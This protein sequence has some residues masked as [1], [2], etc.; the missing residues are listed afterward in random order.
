MSARAFSYSFFS[1]RK[2][3]R[4]RV[5]YMLPKP[6]KTGI[7]N[8]DIPPGYERLH[9]PGVRQSSEQSQAPDHISGSGR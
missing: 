9:D 1:Q 7:L 3:P 6:D 5:Q 8:G 4:K 2:I